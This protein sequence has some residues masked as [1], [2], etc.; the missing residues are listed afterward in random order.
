MQEKVIIINKPVKDANGVVQ[1]RPMVIGDYNLFEMCTQIE[2]SEIGS[3]NTFEYRCK[4]W[5]TQPL[6]ANAS[7]AGVA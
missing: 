3:Y 5:P 7:L 2:N 1:K 4:L 6:L